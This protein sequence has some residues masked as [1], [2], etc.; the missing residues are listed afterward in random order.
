MTRSFSSEQV[1]RGS[2]AS[3]KA[4]ERAASIEPMCTLRLWARCRESTARRRCLAEEGK[5]P[6][7]PRGEARVG[8]SATARKARYQPDRPASEHIDAA[9]AGAALSAAS[10]LLASV[11]SR[12][13]AELHRRGPAGGRKRGATNA[14]IHEPPPEA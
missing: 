4:L 11:S 2:S 12:G 6:S 3:S 7:T 8:E 10:R 14:T 5:P 9:S 1:S 13:A